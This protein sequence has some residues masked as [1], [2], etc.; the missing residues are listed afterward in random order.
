MTTAL[1]CASGTKKLTKEYH[2]DSVDCAT[3]RANLLKFTYRPAEGYIHLN[4]TTEMTEILAR[5]HGY[6]LFSNAYSF[7]G[8]GLVAVGKH[9]T[10]WG[11]MSSCCVSTQILFRKAE[12]HEYIKSVVAA[13]D[14]AVDQ[15]NS[16]LLPVYSVA[17]YRSFTRILR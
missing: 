11:H 12:A 2:T 3:N 9:M 13:N 8:G 14:L 1:W 10:V 17:Y 5:N 7:D 16:L 4:L 6:L 15:W